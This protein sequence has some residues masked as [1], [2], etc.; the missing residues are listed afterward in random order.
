M[1]CGKPRSGAETISVQENTESSSAERLTGFP[2]VWKGML[3]TYSSVS[4]E[5]RSA[6]SLTRSAGTYRPRQSTLPNVLGSDRIHAWFATI[7]ANT[8]RARAEESCAPTGSGELALPN[9]AVGQMH[10]SPTLSSFPWHYL[11]IFCFILIACG[12]ILGAYLYHKCCTRRA[13]APGV[14][15]EQVA[16]RTIGVQSPTTYTSLRGVTQ[17]RFHP[18]PE[19]SHGVFH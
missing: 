8:M 9:H 18:L 19:D 17:P 11:L 2:F 16:K 3:N 6:L 15:P 5:T 13:I 4:S 1:H 10:T 14:P 7:L 12:A